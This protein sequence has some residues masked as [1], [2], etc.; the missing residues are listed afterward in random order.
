[1]HIDYAYA[2]YSGK[3][4]S[5]IVDD[6]MKYYDFSLYDSQKVFSYHSQRLHYRLYIIRYINFGVKLDLCI[7]F[8]QT[9]V[10]C[11]IRKRFLNIMSANKYK[12]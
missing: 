11:Q 7:L 9:N 6:I 10:K 12:R 3:Q 5:T 8:V 2:F 1:M 4:N